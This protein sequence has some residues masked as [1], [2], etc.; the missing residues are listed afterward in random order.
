MINSADKG[1]L[2]KLLRGVFFAL[3]DWNVGRVDG[4]GVDRSLVASGREFIF[5][6]NPSPER[7]REGTSEVQQA[8]DHFEAAS[9]LMFRKGELFNILVS[10]RKRRHRELTKKVSLMR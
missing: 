2:H 3:Y 10:D 1:S 7:L 5:P 6:I 8:L 9:P 4:T